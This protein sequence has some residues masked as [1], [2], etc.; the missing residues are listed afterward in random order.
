MI[1]G[2]PG[3]QQIMPAGQRVEILDIELDLLA[4]PDEPRDLFGMLLR[5]APAQ[6]AA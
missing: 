3:R 4:A 1:V 2:V 6:S 5:A